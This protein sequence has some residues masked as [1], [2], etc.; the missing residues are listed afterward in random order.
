M[1]RLMHPFRMAEQIENNALYFIYTGSIP[2]HFQVNQLILEL[3]F[4]SITMFYK[5]L[6]LAFLLLKLDEKYVCGV[7]GMRWWWR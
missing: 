7:G 1:I 3:F 5:L 2:G 6:K 4:P